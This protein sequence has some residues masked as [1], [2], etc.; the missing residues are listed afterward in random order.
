[1]G[2]TAMAK[3]F[4]S[5]LTKTAR[6]EPGLL[7][8]LLRTIEEAGRLPMSAWRLIHAVE[9]SRDSA[10]SVA[11]I[12][13]DDLLVSRRVLRL[14]NGAQHAQLGPVGS[15]NEAVYRLG[16]TTILHMIFT[17]HL[18][19]LQESAMIY[20]A[21]S[22]DIGRHADATGIVASLIT[23]H[24]PDAGISRTVGVAGMMH[25][26]GKV[27]ISRCMESAGPGRLKELGTPAPLFA[28]IERD[29]V[30][31][32]HAEAG[33]LLARR[34]GLPGVVAIAI[35]DHH[36][37]GS[38]NRDPTAVA[39][40]LANVIAKSIGFGP[41][42]DGREVRRCLELQKQIGLDRDDFYRIRAD[43]SRRLH[44]TGGGAARP[45]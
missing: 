9:D 29:V 26:I 11:E 28:D 20:R 39:V 25:D 24:A 18:R 21:S 8:I 44:L 22:A 14:A 42:P 30:G 38:E 31:L 13:E 32:D 16:S 36:R 23:R 5:R 10:D 7:A 17:D 37:L 45:A 2:A 33:A 27:M 4:D 40:A 34:W 35:Q 41:P 19:K 6:Q 15:L 43:A 1:M 12:V 3:A